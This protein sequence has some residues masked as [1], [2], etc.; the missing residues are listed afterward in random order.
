MHET[1]PLPDDRRSHSL[2]HLLVPNGTNSTDSMSP[3]FLPSNVN[4]QLVES[5]TTHHGVGADG[6][7]HHGSRSSERWQPRRERS[8]HW[9]SHN[10]HGAGSKHGR[11]KSLSEALKTIRGRRGS[12]SANA[13]E[14]ADALKAPVSP[15][16]IVRTRNRA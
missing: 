14:L 3:A 12:V 2:T 11:Q 4:G 10:A 7:V 5:Q 6:N 16:L 1:I 13:H 9:A 8:L 15:K